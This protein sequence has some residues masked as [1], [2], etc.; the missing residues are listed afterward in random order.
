ML[1]LSEQGYYFQRLNCWIGLGMA[2]L[3]L[4][5]IKRS[6]LLDTIVSTGIR[7][8]PNNPIEIQFCAE[9]L[10]GHYYTNVF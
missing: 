9:I 10:I 7:P 6:S 1:L 8:L 5:E 3:H 2:T 4:H